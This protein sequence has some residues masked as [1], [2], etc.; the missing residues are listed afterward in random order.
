MG[1]KKS[2]LWST[3]QEIPHTVIRRKLIAF[4]IAKQLIDFIPNIVQYYS[5]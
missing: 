4:V 2:S 5:N 1:R 3:V